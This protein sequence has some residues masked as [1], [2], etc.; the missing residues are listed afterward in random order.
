MNWLLSS[1]QRNKLCMESLESRQMF[2]VAPFQLE[3]V[4]PTSGTFGE[5]VSPED[6]AGQT[7]VWYFAHST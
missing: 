4:N 2:A 7:S 5:L 1:R 6:F 3:D